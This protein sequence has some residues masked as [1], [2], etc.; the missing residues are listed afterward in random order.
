MAILSIVAS[1]VYGAS[2]LDLITDVIPLVGWVD[3][4]LIVPL[5]LFIGISALVKR[6]RA[7]KAAGAQTGVIDVPAHV[8]P[9]DPE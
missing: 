1:I 4:A 9:K 2:P 5:L 6:H 3:D 7:A 8:V